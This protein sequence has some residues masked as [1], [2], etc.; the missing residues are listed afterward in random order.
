[1]HI[2]SNLDETIQIDT[3]FLCEKLNPFMSL[4][5]HFHTE[6]CSNFVFH[7]LWLY[8]SST[9][10]TDQM[11]ENDIIIWQV[12]FISISPDYILYGDL[13]PFMPSVPLK[14]HEQ[15]QGSNFTFFQTGRFS[16][17]PVF[18]TSEIR[19]WLAFNRNLIISC[20]HFIYLIIILN[21]SDY[22][23]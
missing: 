7:G 1:M 10:Q 8:I 23:S 15:T 2:H 4:F 9:N 6:I 5:S 20:C 16:P 22:K 13:E 3:M 21:K 11:I 14:G 19:F 18:S 17:V 12:V